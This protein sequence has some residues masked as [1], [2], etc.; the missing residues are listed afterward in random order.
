MVTPDEEKAAGDDRLRKLSPF[1]KMMKDKCL[2]LYQPIKTL[3][4]D[5]RMVK[6]KARFHLIL[7]KPI[8]WGFKLWVISDPTGYT[9]DFNVYTG[10]SD[11]HGEYGLA[12][13][14]VKELIAPYVFQ[15]YFVSF[16]NFYTSPILLEDL[17][18]QEVYATGTFRADRRS[19]PRT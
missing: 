18:K 11:N 3:S 13:D 15:R 7:N 10:K 12:Y 2:E 5:E 14:V 16:D 1:L 17:L 4:I 19:I 6:S 8:K 9:L